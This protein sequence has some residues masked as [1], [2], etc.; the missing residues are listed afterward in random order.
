LE[1]MIPRR[2]KKQRISAH[3]KLDV[4]NKPQTILTNGNKL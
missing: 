3:K 1:V 4:N 2:I